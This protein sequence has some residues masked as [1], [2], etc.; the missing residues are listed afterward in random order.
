MVTDCWHKTEEA[1]LAIGEALHVH[2]E[3]FSFRFKKSTVTQAI[4]VLPIQYMFLKRCDAAWPFLSEPS[5]DHTVL[6]TAI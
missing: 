2:H 4:N 5:S 1:K 3:A 6:P